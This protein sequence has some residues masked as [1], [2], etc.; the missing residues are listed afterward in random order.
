MDIN[1]DIDVSVTQA[2][3]LKDTLLF[4]RNINLIPILSLHWIQEKYG[5][6]AK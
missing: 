6:G 4:T 1:Y 5:A 3:Q 2:L